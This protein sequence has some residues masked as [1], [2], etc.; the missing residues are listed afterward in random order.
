MTYRSFKEKIDKIQE[1]TGLAPTVMEKKCALG[2]GTITKNYTLNK[3]M[4]SN[5][6]KIFLE[7]MGINREWWESGKGDVL[8]KKPTQVEL[9]SSKTPQSEM[10]KMKVYQSL[11]EGSTPYIL[12]HA[13]IIEEY[14]MVPKEIITMLSQSAAAQTSVKELEEKYIQLIEGLKDEIELLRK[15][16]PPDVTGK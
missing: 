10:E 5:S 7:E 14:R 2:Q 9:S 16:L 15:K 3:E 13:S 8:V 1:I 6:T 4:S 12:Q 11:I